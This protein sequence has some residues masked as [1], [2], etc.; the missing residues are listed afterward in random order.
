MA[1]D[2]FAL[3]VQ[4]SDSESADLEIKC[5]CGILLPEFALPGATLDVRFA[6][7]FTVASRGDDS[8]AVMRHVGMAL[9]EPKRSRLGEVQRFHSQLAINLRNCTYLTAELQ[10]ALSNDDFGT[11]Y[12]SLR[13]LEAFPISEVKIDKSFVQGLRQSR[14]KS[15]I[16]ETVIKPAAELNILV[17][18]EGVDLRLIT[19]RSSKA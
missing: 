2:E 18:A 14:V 4:I 15:I 11:G 10:Q 3:V 16:V 6:I 17:T 8:T 12:S 7:G 13:Y 19:Q 5:L 9:Q 1:T